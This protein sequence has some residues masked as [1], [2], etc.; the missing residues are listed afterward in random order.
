[1]DFLVSIKSSTMC[2]YKWK[3]IFMV[4]S[5]IWSPAGH[6]SGSPPFLLYINDITAGISSTIRLFADDCIVYRVI[7]SDSDCSVLQSDINYMHCWALTWQMQFNSNKCHIL[8]VGCRHKKLTPSYYL[9]SVKLSVVD[10]YP[11]L[12][13]TISS[14]LRWDKHTSAVSH[15]ATRTL[16]FVRRNIYG[17]TPDTKALAYTSLVRPLLE[18][19]AA[20]WD[21][22][23]AKDISKLDMGQRRAARFV[24]SDYRRTTSV[25]G[26]IGELD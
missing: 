23:R 16:N 4:A 18:Y 24:K 11:Y 5:Y 17:C 8:S 13:V 25:S 9:G 10:S 6:S 26:L 19:A 22:Y 2:C 1:M 3:S 7:K 12:G 20:A 15:K 14:D 21:P